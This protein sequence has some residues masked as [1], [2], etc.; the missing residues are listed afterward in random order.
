MT[1]LKATYA[2]NIAGA[3]AVSYRWDFGDGTAYTGPFADDFIGHTYDVCGTYT[4]R[5]EVTD[6]YGNV[7]VGSVDM[8]INRC[9]THVIY[10]PFIGR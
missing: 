6:N 7:T 8:P 1:Q 10:L 2:S 3:Q 9:A 4:V 5:V